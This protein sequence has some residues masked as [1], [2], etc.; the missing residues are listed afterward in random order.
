VT[1]SPPL[2]LVLMPEWELE[3][4]GPNVLLIEPWRLKTAS[5]PLPP[6][7]EY[8]NDIHFPPRARRIISLGR[9]LARAVAPLRPLERRASTIR[10]VDAAEMERGSVFVQRR[11]G[12]DL[13]RWG[14]YEGIDAITRLGENLGLFPLTRG[15]PPPG[16][17]YEAAASFTLDFIPDDLTL[18]FEDLG[19]PTRLWLNGRELTG[20]CLTD[21][22]W[23]PACRGFAVSTLVKKGRNRLRIKSRQPD[24]PGLA[25]SL[26][27]LEPVAIYGT[28]ALA[29]RTV[30]RP[31]P[32]P[33]A[34]GNFTERGYRFYSGAMTMRCRFELPADYLGFDL[35]LELGEVREV[36][37]ARLNGRDAGTRVHPPFNFDVTEMARAGAN[38][39]EVRVYNSA[40]NL[41]GRPQPSGIL[42]AIRVAAFAPEGE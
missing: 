12:I 5:V 36:A 40:A 17:E 14:V 27:A 30:V 29:D 39:L 24:W 4:A 20:E 13:D 33:A 21:V 8:R 38:E 26:P 23:D 32:G 19:E 1:K 25:P 15:F 42:S 22:G 3:P 9:G 2:P 37:S 6:P 11:A 34:G 16:A 7:E 41:L 31:Q 35:W 18:V 28:F 10:Y